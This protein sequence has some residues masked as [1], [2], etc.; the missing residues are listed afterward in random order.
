MVSIATDPA[1]PLV[2]PETPILPT[3]LPTV[4]EL[5]QWIV[6]LF[7]K[8]ALRPQRYGFYGPHA[9]GVCAIGVI[10][11]EAGIR[12]SSWGQDH[13]RL[14]IAT[15]QRKFDLG[16][17]QATGFTMACARGFD[18]PQST[19]RESFAT[20]FDSDGATWGSFFAARP[21]LDRVEFASGFDLGLAVGHE[22]SRLV[23]GEG[24]G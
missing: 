7:G 4:H 14:V 23:F 5:S 8:Y 11:V 2:Q 9:R 20:L 12:P 21:E 15:I 19:A 10:G 6:S 16:F 17:S 24:R 3:S 18:H 1:A 13:T 22:V